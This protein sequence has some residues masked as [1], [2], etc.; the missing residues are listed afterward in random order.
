M[1]WLRQS[2]LADL[3]DTYGSVELMRVRRSRAT[4]RRPEGVPPRR[5]RP[6]AMC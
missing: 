1:K 2:S 5:H 4:A 3:R 6:T